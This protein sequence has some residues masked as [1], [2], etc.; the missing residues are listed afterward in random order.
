MSK[1]GYYH[2]TLID[3]GNEV[4]LP[5]PNYQYKTHREV[6]MVITGPK[7]RMAIFKDCNMDYA[8]QAIK[9]FMEFQNG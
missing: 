1:D 2:P 3:C 9:E 5:N 4:E 7:G 6:Q 8:G